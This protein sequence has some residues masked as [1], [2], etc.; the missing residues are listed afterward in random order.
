MKVVTEGERIYLDEQTAHG[1]SL[2]YM[3]LSTI[4]SATVACVAIIG[5]VWAVASSG[6][7][8]AYIVRIDPDGRYETVAEGIHFKRQP[9][10]VSY[11]IRQFCEH[12]FS[13][14]PF[15]ANAFERHQVLLRSQR[16]AGS[17]GSMAP[18]QS[19]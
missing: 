5:F 6:Q 19:I 11:F 16:P 7:R 18:G 3:R 1:S 2:G 4:A 10:E 12:Y 9:S 17:R 14:S 8:H 15:A 13:R